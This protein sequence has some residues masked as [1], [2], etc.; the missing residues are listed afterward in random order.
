MDGP[1]RLRWIRGV[2]FS[3]V[4]GGCLDKDTSYYDQRTSF[5]I[6]HT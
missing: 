2:D 4:A 5:R 3:F 1:V 6:L